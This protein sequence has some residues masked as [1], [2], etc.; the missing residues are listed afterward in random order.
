M[1]TTN[2]ASG[3]LQSTLDKRFKIR[4]QKKTAGKQQ[5]A[6]PASDKAGKSGAK[7]GKKGGKK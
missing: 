6:A 1:K 2:L 5:Q 4:L 7:A 3:Y